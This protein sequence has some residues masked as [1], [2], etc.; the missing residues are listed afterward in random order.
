MANN[1]FVAGKIYTNKETD[2]YGTDPSSVVTNRQSDS[3]PTISWLCTS[4]TPTFAVFKSNSGSPSGNVRRLR[5]YRDKNGDYVF[6]RNRFS[7][8]PVFRS[9]PSYTLFRDWLNYPTLNSDDENGAFG[10]AI[11]FTRGSTA[12][13]TGSNGLIQ[14]AAI[15]APRFDYD[16]I[17]LA[18]K[19]LLIEEARANLFLQSNNFGTNWG[20]ASVLTLTPNATASPDGASNGWSLVPAAS[21][22]FWRINQNVSVVSGTTYTLS[23]Y[24]KANGYNFVRFEPSYTTASQGVA[25]F[26]LVNGTISTVAG[27][28]T[29]S[30]TNV[31]NG[32][33]RCS[34]SFI[35][36]TTGGGV[37]YFYPAPFN[38]SANY[39]GN[40]T[41]G[42]FLY[43][44]QL[45]AGAFASSYIP[46]TTATVTRSADVAQIT[47]SNFTSFYNQ[48]AGT[49]FANAVTNAPNAYSLN[50][51]YFEASD[52][53]NNNRLVA[54]RST[55]GSNIDWR[56][57][58]GGTPYN[59]SAVGSIAT[60]ILGKVALAATSGSARGSVNGSLTTTTTAPAGMPT[61]NRI[62]I[63]CS[64]LGGS[65]SLNG[66]LSSIAYYPTRLT[67]D[68]L[69]SLTA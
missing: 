14:S 48:S 24:A 31:G 17:T 7:G 1:Y 65:A 44:A 19:G 29:A 50:Q 8:A 20:N 38:N 36:T 67:D 34:S 64:V 21:L 35:S 56:V 13:F 53:T 62:A 69:Q 3:Q 16:P 37:N 4:V 43:G 49:L 6:P 61:L 28:T 42:I 66:W 23:V 51:T 59:P 5:I 33:Y 27:N 12:T 26:D 39:T 47:G 10:P 9:L 40:G 25:S 63:G 52:G 45:E 30:I 41:S 58:N 57:V 68:Q 46:T 18:G 32:W 55:F 2:F 11:E 15:N 22:A 60:G 54:F